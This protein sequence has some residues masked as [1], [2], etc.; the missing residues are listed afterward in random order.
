MVQEALANESKTRSLGW[1]SSKGTTRFVFDVL[2]DERSY[3][4]IGGLYYMPKNRPDQQSSPQNERVLVGMRVQKIPKWI[5]ASC[6][7][8]TPDFLF[9]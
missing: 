5:S 2:P 1:E 3:D 8:W 9:E 4:R 6:I 7:R